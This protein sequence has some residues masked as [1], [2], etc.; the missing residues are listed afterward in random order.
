[1]N[2]QN[3]VSATDHSSFADL[4][5][6]LAPHEVDVT[7]L[8]VALCPDFENAFSSRGWLSL[9]SERLYIGSLGESTYD[10]NEVVA[11]VLS[12]LGHDALSELSDGTVDDAAQ[13]ALSRRVFEYMTQDVFSECL[14]AYE[15]AV[16]EL[17]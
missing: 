16:D 7:R 15:E 8:S 12:D 1:M 5:D 14:S 10:A 13:D 4:V 2:D 17:P 3:L 9:A 11:S 6:G